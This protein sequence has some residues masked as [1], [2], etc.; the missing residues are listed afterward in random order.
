MPG[1]SRRG[2]HPV[3]RAMGAARSAS[4]LEWWLESYSRRLASHA[5]NEGSVR[6]HL[7]RSA[8]AELRLDALHPIGGRSLPRH[9]RVGGLATPDRQPPPGLSFAGLRRGDPGWTLARRQP[10]HARPQAEGAEE[11][12]WAITC[13]SRRFLAFSPSST[14]GGGLS[15]QQPSTRAYERA[16]SL[17]S[18]ARTSTSR[19]GS[20]SSG[21]AGTARPRRAV[22]P[23]LCPSPQPSCP[24][25]ARPFSSPPPSS[26][27]PTSAAAVARRRA[28]PARAACFRR[29]V[30]LEAV[31]RRAAWSR[32]HRA[33]MEA[34][35]PSAGLWAQGACFRRRSPALPQVRDAALAQAGRPSHS[36]PRPPSHDGDSAS[37]REGAP[38][39]RA[40]G[41]PTPRPEADRAGLRTPR[42]RLPQ[43]RR[44]PAPLRGDARACIGSV[45][46][47]CERERDPRGTQPAG[48]S[49]GRSPEAKTRGHPALLT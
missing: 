38:G 43:R 49:K 48:C 33:R 28:V 21:A 42:R 18:G 25:C 26:S 6:R 17:R 31:L 27:F 22:T 12:R 35:V 15:S 16:S 39:R 40:E 34:R 4:L 7:V 19:P 11:P 24:G 47:V 9:E 44:R 20:W 3:F 13:A 5:S 30:A 10:R 8:L 29:E 2:L 32:G 37:S 23:T 1:G 45:H 14:H 41:A 36:V 46:R